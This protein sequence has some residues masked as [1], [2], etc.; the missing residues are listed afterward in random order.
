MPGTMLRAF[1]VL[2]FNNCIDYTHYHH[3][4]FMA[5]KTE[6]QRVWSLAQVTHLS[7]CTDSIRTHD[8]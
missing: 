5:Q 1:A 2:S 7:S 3:P 4:N 8:W 6:A